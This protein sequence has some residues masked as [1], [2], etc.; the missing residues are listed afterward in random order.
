[1]TERRGVDGH[2]MSYRMKV[3]RDIQS[4]HTTH[5]LELWYEHCLL[6]LWYPFC[7]GPVELSWNCVNKNNIHNF[8]EQ[9]PRF[10][11][12]L[13]VG[14]T[15]VKESNKP[16]LNRFLPSDVQPKENELGS[17]GRVVGHKNET[18][19]PKANILRF[20]VQR[21]GKARKLS[22]QTLTW[23]V[24][25]AQRQEAFDHNHVLWEETRASGKSHAV[26]LKLL[27]SEYIMYN[28][29]VFDRVLS[30]EAA[31]G[32]FR[33][34]DRAM[35]RKDKYEAI[36]KD[37]CKWDVWAPD[38]KVMQW[39]PLKSWREQKT[40]DFLFLLLL[41]VSAWSLYFFCSPPPLSSCSITSGTPPDPHKL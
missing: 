27:V 7:W 33:R 17:P 30:Q 38:Q 5:T 14:R 19:H 6:F 24:R 29:K 35:A 21:R 16:S 15:A 23:Q 41:R 2:I 40:W 28:K 25:V 31:E 39:I 22:A 4:T 8:S 32:I 10:P 18:I 20:E 3:N 11:C 36:L 1:M 9:I 37:V 26:M 34:I 13:L 12:F